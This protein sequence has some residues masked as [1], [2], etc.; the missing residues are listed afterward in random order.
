MICL[1]SYIIIYSECMC[2]YFSHDLFSHINI[3][4]IFG[5]LHEYK[6][7][8]V[9][10]NFLFLIV[11]VLNKYDRLTKAMFQSWMNTVLFISCSIFL[12]CSISCPWHCSSWAIIQ[13]WVGYPN[14]MS[15]FPWIEKTSHAIPTSWTSHKTSH[16]TFTANYFP[17]IIEVNELMNCSVSE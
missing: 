17:R 8:Y 12:Y 10:M 2:F 13:I 1:F 3:W 7:L 14:I 5:W 9:E 11:I 15:V 16:S 4:F 6:A